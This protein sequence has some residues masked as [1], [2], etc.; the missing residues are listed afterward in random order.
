MLMYLCFADGFWTTLKNRNLTSMDVFG[1]V[2]CTLR[3]QFARIRPQM[4]CNCCSD[5][6][7][8]MLYK[9]HSGEMK[10]YRVVDAFLTI[11]TIICLALRS[12]M[13][14]FL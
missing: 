14:L 10:I 5:V 2:Q 12:P 11:I 7:V 9:L 3:T 1:C 6:R 8:S 4:R 13:Q